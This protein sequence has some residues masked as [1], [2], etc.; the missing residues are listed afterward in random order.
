[1]RNGLTLIL[2][3][4]TA[5]AAAASNIDLATVP[6]RETV[7][8]TIYN[9]EDLTLVRETRQIVFTPGN[10]PLQ[11][12]WA[13]TLIDPTSVQLRFLSHADKLDVLDTTFPHD[14]PQELVWN[15]GSEHAGEAT[16]EIS[17]FTSGVTWS[18]DYT[19]IA[20]ADESAAR[21]EGFVTVSNN[22]G[23]SYE[24]A[25]VRLVVGT[26]NL[27]EQIADLAQRAGQDPAS[28]NEAERSYFQRQ[29]AR[30]MVLRAEAADAAPTSTSAP[31]RP[32]EIVKQ[33]L[34]EYFIFTIEGTETVPHGSR[35]RMPS[36]AA[37]AVPLRVEYRY[38]PAE[39]GHQL[40]QLYLM[41]NDEASELGQSPLPDGQVR[42]L[43]RK[44]DGRGL[45]FVARQQVRYI[46]IGEDIEVNLG[47]DPDVAFSRTPLRV[48]RENI[49]LQVRTP[50]VIRPLDEPGG[51]RFDSRS[52]VI[53]WDQHEVIRRRI[54]NGTA[55]PINVEIREW[56]SGDA[57]IVADLG[58]ER[59]DN[60]TAVYRETLAAG[61]R[62]D[63]VFEAVTRQGRNAKQQRLEI[64]NALPA[65]VAR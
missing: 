22:S 2:T 1:M 32:K 14:R 4:W 8:L 50:D 31:A 53:G 64:R 17:Y 16:V 38:R 18:A 6:D 19:V 34:S 30:Q 36:F 56:I 25:Q 45:S 48:F 26:I 44:A 47:P 63:A 9:S 21:V 42:V 40:V 62:W 54:H 23:E 3:L 57:T 37:E 10:N 41:T 59:H 20:E 5:T 7:Q 28:L 39:Y 33:G 24:D 11:F 60:Q 55:R 58:M 61:E 51:V 46:P 15:V 49:W 52:R 43:R 35:K 65:E 27:V 13:N 12:S 29:S